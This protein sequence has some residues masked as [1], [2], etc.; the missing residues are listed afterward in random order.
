M[1][2]YA[3]MIVSNEKAVYHI[4]S[5]TCL[6]GFPFGDV[7]KDEFVKIIKN[8]SGL[9]FVE[10]MGFCIMGNHFHLLI[11]MLPEHNFSDNEIRNR[12]LNFF[13]Q[14][15]EKTF[16]E[17]H[18]AHYRE[19]WGNLSEYIKDIKQT[20]SRYYNK[21]HDRRGTLWGER[22]K[23]VIVENG[24]TLVNCL[25]YI[26]LNPLRAGLV[27]R[28]EEYRWNSIG[29]HV[30]TDNRDDF[31]S[32]DFGLSEFGNRNKKERFEGYRKHLYEAGALDRSGTGTKKIIE[33]KIIIK[34]RNRK[35]KLS[36]AD[37]FLYK[38][39]YFTDS[40][41]IGS[42]AFVS[43]NYQKFQH[44][45]QCKDKKPKTISG[46]DGIYSMKRLIEA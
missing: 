2:R 25:S 42:K 45:F 18:I 41:V 38:T 36:R 17:G 22:F 24:H 46:L 19:K 23:S 20:F 14:D 43:E 13:G 37:R 44:L 34:E 33:D 3:R 10:V 4:M 26:D 9:Y 8:F 40:G 16:S 29:Y 28:P 21:R 32:L 15:K 5:R 35:Y 30:Q 1:P 6:A 39:R 31:L 11:K 12:Y 27:K 7:E